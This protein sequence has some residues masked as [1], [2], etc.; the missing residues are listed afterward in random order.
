MCL[1]T[2]D[3]CDTCVSFQTGNITENE[4][5]DHIERKNEARTE[6]SNDKDSQND[7]FTMDLQSVLL[8]PKSNLSSLYKTKLIFHNFTIYDIKRQTGFCYFWNES[9]EGLT[10]NEF[11]SIIIHFLKRHVEQYFSREGNIKDIEIILWSDGCGYQNRNT[12]LS[13]T[14]FNF[15][16][17][18]GITVVQKYLQKGHTQMEVDSVHSV[19]ERKIRNKK[20]NIPADYVCICKTA[21]QKAPYTVEYLMHDFLKRYDKIKNFKS[22]RPG[23]IAGAP[24]VNDLKRGYIF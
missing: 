3:L 22:I 7:V 23:K 14:L 5:N 24:I 19:I 20:V 16:L 18:G 9:E 10:S 1:C 11:T 6:K 2:C 8:C 13:N 21:C 4:Y 12:I 17:D 15:A